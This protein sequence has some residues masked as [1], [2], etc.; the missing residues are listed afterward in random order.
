MEIMQ[1]KQTIKL[2]FSSSYLLALDHSRSEFAALIFL[3]VQ[4]HSPLS[5]LYSRLYGLV[6]TANICFNNM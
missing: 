5:G 4:N 1:I 6:V 2:S 3:D